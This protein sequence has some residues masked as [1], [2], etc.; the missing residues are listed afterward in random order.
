MLWVE[1][2]MLDGCSETV[3]VGPP[4]DADWCSC[5]KIPTWMPIEHE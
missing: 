3:G 4:P 2:I 5:P 1:K